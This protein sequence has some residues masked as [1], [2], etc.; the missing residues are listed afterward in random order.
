MEESESVQKC[1]TIKKSQENFLI[2]ERQFKLSRFV[3][4]KL[5]E[6]IKMRKEYKEF[7]DA[8]SNKIIETIAKEVVI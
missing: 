2:G 5:D 8:D 4:V 6:Y 1:I 3:Q 7:M